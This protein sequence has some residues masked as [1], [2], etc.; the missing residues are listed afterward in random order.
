MA[1]EPRLV[2]PGQTHLVLQSALQGLAPLASAEDRAD[3]LA[4]LRGA[5]ARLGVAWHGF[6]LQGHAA[7]LLLTPPDAAALSATV[8]AVGRLFVSAHNRRQA[9]SGTVWDG[10]FRCSVL[11]PGAHRLRALLLLDTLADGVPAA[12]SAAQHLGEDDGSPALPAIPE[13]WALGNTPFEREAAY[14]Q[15]AEAATDAPWRAGMMAAA[16]RGQAIGD[17]SW[18]AAQA[19]VSGRTLLPK[20]RG[21]PRRA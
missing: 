10:R 8:Q 21:R 4:A 12:S 18:L 13:Y 15:L 19:Q 5:A 17:A 14:R 2:L 1:R 11:Q 7:W 3:Y 6:A 16:A 9:R 20:S